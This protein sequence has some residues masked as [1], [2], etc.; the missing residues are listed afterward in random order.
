MAELAS[1]QIAP[2]YF[3]RTSDPCPAVKD[4]K[5]PPGAM[6]GPAPTYGLADEWINP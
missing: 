4:G 3:F 2:V 5:S 1:N 6:D